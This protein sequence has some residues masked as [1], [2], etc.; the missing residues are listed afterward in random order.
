MGEYGVTEN[1]FV[2][3]RLDT[4]LEEVHTDLTQ[5]FGFDTR[6][7]RPS[8]IDTLVTSFSNQIAELWETAQDSYYSKFP[9]TAEGKN[10]DNA[11]QFG[12]IRRKA[13][14]PTTYP[15]HCQGNDGTAIRMGAVI[16]TETMPEIRLA[17]KTDSEITRNS[18]NKITIKPSVVEQG[19]YSIAING[20]VYSYSSS[21]SD[22]ASVILTELK[23]AIES[24]TSEFLITVASDQITIEDKTLDRSDVIVLSDNLTSTSVTSIIMFDTEEY[25]AITLPNTTISKIITNISGF[26]SVTNIIAPT[27]GRLEETDIELRQSYI[28]KSALRS[29]TMIDSITSELLTNVK[30]VLSSSG[31]ENDTNSVDSEGRPPHS[32]EIVV[33]GGSDNDIANVILA[34][35]AAGIQTYGDTTIDVYTK[36]GQVIPISF[37]RPTLLYAWFKVNVTG[38]NLPKNAAFLTR[39]SIL[40]DVNKLA[41]GDSLLIQKLHEGIYQTVTNTRNVDIKVAY[42]SDK[43][44]IPTA[45]EYKSENIMVIMREK[46]VTE[47]TRIEVVINDI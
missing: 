29:T 33:E 22:T 20:V 19:V 26:N 31:Y 1:G 41:S 11:V 45:S 6:L 5:G 18:C 39:D 16:A 38:S 28:A 7:T 21:G 43:N 35:K 8:L 47:S 9:A 46:I 13:A 37:S 17:A 32:I 42:N 14:A 30:N 27:M 36:Y 44:H 12:G 23:G 3:K 4:I 2:L 40:N 34:K 10:L 25:G 15:I 24:L